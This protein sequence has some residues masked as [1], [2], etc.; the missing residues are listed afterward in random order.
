MLTTWDAFPMLNRLLDDVMN[1]VTGTAFGT[2]A[3]VT[4]DPAIDVRAT[5]DELIFVCDVPGVTQ[6]DLEVAIEGST[7]TIKGQRNYSGGEKDKVWL[8]RSYGAFAKSFTLPEFVDA[9]AMTAALS[10][11]VLTI[12]VPKK[13]Q[14]K[15]R[16]IQIGSGS[17]PRQL[18]E[19][20]E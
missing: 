7:L 5:E 14:A 2:G 12:N 16:K 8:G 4:I 17:S 15:P 10:N 13:P 20:K 19:K 11:G 1:D 6:E 3:K 18:E 9:N